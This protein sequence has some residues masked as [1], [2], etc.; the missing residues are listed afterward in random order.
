MEVIS[1]PTLLLWNVKIKTQQKLGVG[2]FLSLS[3]F[4]IILAI[5]KASGLK[6][7]ADSFALV[8]EIFWQQV[9]A[10]VAVLMV[11]FTAFRSVFVS[12]ASNAKRKRSYPYARS[13]LHFFEGDPHRNPIQTLPL[14]S[15]RWARHSPWVR[16]STKLGIWGLVEPSSET[17]L[18]LME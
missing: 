12:S 2:V 3:I 13:L 8:W 16:G 9:E 18:N 4:M 5:I 11:S 6:T 10:A 14:K 7:S 17:R 15:S 1:I